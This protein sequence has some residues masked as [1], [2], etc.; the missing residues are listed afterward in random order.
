VYRIETLRFEPPDLEIEVEC[1]KGTYIRSL[2][3]DLGE[4][5]GCGAHLS[6][7][8]RTAIGPFRIG[9]AVGM[10][11]L[12]RAFETG[13]WE[14]HL[15]PLDY[16]LLHLPAV[17]LHIEDEK[18]IR[19]GQSV[20]LDADRIE[21]IG[22]IADGMQARAY[23]EDGSLVAIIRYDSAAKIWRPRKVFEAQRGS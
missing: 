1:G 14:G 4:Q 13:R 3:Q 21:G 10:E 17:T 9:D 18:D 22:P 23:A 11:E 5:L 2:A 6:A 19:H 7:L 8:S 20:A 15:L 12:E 16:G